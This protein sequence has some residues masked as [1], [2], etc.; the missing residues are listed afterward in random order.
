MSTNLNRITFS[1]H[2]L[3]VKE[4]SSESKNLPPPGDHYAAI[5]YLTFAITGNKELLLE[6]AHLKVPVYCG[7]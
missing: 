4:T 2:V 5:V 7:C 1:L 3:K 6:T